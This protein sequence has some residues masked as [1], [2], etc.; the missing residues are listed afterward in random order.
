MID[1]IL[2][3]QNEE[4]VTSAA[5]FAGRVMLAGVAI[6][7]LPKILKPYVLSGRSCFAVTDHVQ[8]PWSFDSTTKRKEL[9]DFRE[10]CP[11]L[12]RARDAAFRSP[13]GSRKSLEEARFA[14]NSRCQH[15]HKVETSI[16]T[17]D[18]DDILQWHVQYAAGTSDPEEFDADMICKRLML[19]NVGSVVTT[20]GA[21]AHLISDLFSL[22]NIEEVIE[23]LRAEICQVLEEE[24]EWNMRGLN[25]L[26]KLDSA[27][28]ESLRISAFSTRICARKVSTVWRSP[29]ILQ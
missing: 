1:Y 14:I 15:S 2:I 26:V 19:F 20:A 18:Q 4:F 11:T 5:S 3:G 28:K 13:C 21:L 25:R 24:K 8:N 9:H 29:H 27:I 23:E 10:A 16:I 17:E 22:S 6:R 7:A 12:D